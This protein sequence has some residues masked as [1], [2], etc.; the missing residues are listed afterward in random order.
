[1]RVDRLRDMRK[2]RQLSQQDIADRTGISMRMVQRYEAGE[3][4]IAVYKGLIVGFTAN[5]QKHGVRRKADE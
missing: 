5:R 1:M 2:Q 3:N 4:R